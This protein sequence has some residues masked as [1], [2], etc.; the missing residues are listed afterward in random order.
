HSPSR[1]HLEPG[2]VSRTGA[3][4]VAALVLTPLAALAARRRWS[5]L[6]LGG[7]MLLLALELAPFLFPRFSDLVSLSQSRRAAGFVPF[8]VAFAGGAAV[9]TRALRIAVLPVALAAGIGLQQFDPHIGSA[10]CRA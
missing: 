9:L 6:V 10:A 7:M 2:L 1:Y 3:I 4:A 8:A 5:A